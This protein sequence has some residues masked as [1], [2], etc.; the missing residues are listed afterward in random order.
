VWKKPIQ[1]DGI[2]RV[3]IISGRGNGTAPDGEVRV[4]LFIDS[5]DFKSCTYKPSQLWQK[6]VGRDHRY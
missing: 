4:A 1:P 2:A 3:E 6:M 5:V